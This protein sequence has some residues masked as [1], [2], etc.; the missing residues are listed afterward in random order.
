[1]I[2]NCP[3]STA[4]W[5]RKIEATMIQAMRSRPKTTPCSPA[6]ATIEAGM[7]KAASA[8]ATAIAMPAAALTQTR[9]RRTTRTKN[10]VTTGSAETSVERGQDPSGS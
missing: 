10:R 8:S 6:A 7:R 9:L 2:S 1:M 3:V 5:Y 4:M